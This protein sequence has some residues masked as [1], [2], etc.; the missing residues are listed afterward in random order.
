MINDVELPKRRIMKRLM[1]AFFKAE[2]NY[3]PVIWM[4][5]NRNL[6]DKINRLH[7]RCLI[8][9]CK[10]QR[11]FRLYTLHKI[12]N[13]FPE[14]MC[15]VFKLRDT[16][17][18]KLWHN[19]QFSIGPVHGVYNETESASYLGPKI[20]EQISTEIENK[21]SL[22]GLKRENKKWKPVECPCRIY[23]TFVPNLDFI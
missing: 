12:I 20:W 21:E 3:G 7:E 8:I 16:P 9:I 2:F 22:D 1:N 15:E 11:Q 23:R 4:F 19:S 14:I 6:N 5:H 17:C 10:R 18:Y 13:M